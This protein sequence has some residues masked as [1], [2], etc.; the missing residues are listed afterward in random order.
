MK[1]SETSHPISSSEQSDSGDGDVPFE[2]GSET[3][4]DTP[5]ETNQ[6]EQTDD[7]GA[8][9]ALGLKFKFLVRCNIANKMSFNLSIHF[10]NI[11][12]FL[13]N[14]CSFLN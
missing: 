7:K 11:E 3:E 1:T 4:Q 6:S 14:Y 9:F 2:N 8:M 13:E 12:L 10:N 5:M